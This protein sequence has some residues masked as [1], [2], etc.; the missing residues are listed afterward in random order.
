MVLYDIF[1]TVLL[2][3]LFLVV[4]G[5]SACAVAQACACVCALLSSGYS[6]GGGG[7]VG[8]RGGK[9]KTRRRNNQDKQDHHKDLAEHPR[10]R[11]EAAAIMHLEQLTG[12]KFPT[13]VPA[14]LGLELDG[15]NA[16]LGIA[17]EFRG[18]LHTKW[19]PTYEPYER[20]YTRVQ[21]DQQK[22][23]ECAKHNVNLIVV[24]MSLPSRHWRNYIASRLY[25]FGI[26]KQP[27][28]Y[29]AEQTA[30]PYRNPQLERELG[31]TPN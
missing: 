7:G 17:L 5:I 2:V 26:G 28:E 25:D 18:P 11:S 16:E 13:I 23:T 22:I 21:R 27:I 12:K 3:V 14:W 19:T 10:S 8:G 15:Y 6:G 4:A 1:I 31:L 24:D 9:G 30:V 20:Y 29:I